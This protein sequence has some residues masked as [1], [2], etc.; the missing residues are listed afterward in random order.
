MKKIWIILLFINLTTYGQELKITAE[1]NPAIVGE[2]ILIQY[3]INAKGDDFSQPKFNGLQILSGPNPSTQRSYTIINGKSTSQSITS[4][5]YYLRAIKE[6]SYTITPAS[7]NVNGKKIS[8]NSYTIKV[9]K[10]AEKSKAEKEALSRKLFVEADVSKRNIVVGEQ[11]L[12]TYKLYTRIQ[13]TNEIINAQPDLN[14]FW[15]K[16]L[17]SSSRYK[18]EIKD[19]VRYD[20]LTLKKSVLTAQ[21][22]GKLK[23]DPIEFECGII[24]Q[25]Q[26]RSVWDLNPF[27]SSNKLQQEIIKSKPITINVSE[28]PNPPKD[29]SGVVG[30][31]RISS[32]IDNST[33]HANEAFT[34][35]LEIKGTG[36]LDLINTLNIKFPDDFEVYDPKISEKIFEGGRKPSKKTFEYIII[37]RFKGEYSIPSVS[38]IT[39]N[40]KTTQYEEQLSNS[41]KLNILE[42]KN[43]EEGSNINEILIDTEQKDINFIATETSLTHKNKKVPFSKKLFLLYFT[44]PL[45][46]LALLYIYEKFINIEDKESVEWKNK[47]ANKIALKR[48]SAAQ[49]CIKENNFERFFEEIEKSLWGYF[50]DKFQ[51]SIADLSKETINIYFKE[52]AIQKI[53]KETFIALLDECEFARYTPSDNRNTQM[54]V[55]LNKAKKIIIEVE[56]ELK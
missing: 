12:V 19:G 25:T 46:L 40:Q 26:R 36:N 14:G 8:S 20:V 51:I 24:L 2:Q 10:A 42:S 54:E 13:I 44:L 22:S 32:T 43:K 31:V 5:S 39:Y 35:K 50:A 16:D 29:Y 6:G 48:L 28:L 7:V 53:T 38:L 27:T 45:L 30:D 21:K 18:R 1:P 56:T 17:K 52:F 3:S 55:T 33:V 9:K 47:Q 37:P 23:I 49:K 11:I 4:Y 41:H 34:Y 15:V